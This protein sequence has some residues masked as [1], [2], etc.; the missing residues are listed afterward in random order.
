MRWALETY[1]SRYFELYAEDID[2]ANTTHPEWRA[3][4]EELASS[5]C[6]L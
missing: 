2:A 6:D 4:Y 1:G 3:A 5:L